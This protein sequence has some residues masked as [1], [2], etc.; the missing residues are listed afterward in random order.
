MGATGFCSTVV[1][2]GGVAGFFGFAWDRE[3]NV[4]LHRPT[5]V[6]S[7]CM[8]ACYIATHSPQDQALVCPVPLKGVN[9]VIVTAASEV[10]EM[11]V[12]AFQSGH[13]SD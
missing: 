11:L 2:G 5:D 9:R 3:S 7:S 13:W 1:V 12:G 10:W 8:F 6:N 4:E